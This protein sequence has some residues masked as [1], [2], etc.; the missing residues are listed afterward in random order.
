MQL[1]Y[2][3]A[4]PQTAAWWQVR[5]LS[6]SLVKHQPAIIPARFVK[7]ESAMLLFASASKQKKD[8]G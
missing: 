5:C 1:W 7:I 3:V 8:G 6:V 4:C 2:W